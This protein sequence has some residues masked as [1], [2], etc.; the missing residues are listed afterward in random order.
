M[1]DKIAD[2]PIDTVPI[3]PEERSIIDGMFIHQHVPLLSNVVKAIV[4]Y[5]SLFAIVTLI[6]SLPDVLIST[7]I[8]SRF[9]VSFKAFVCCILFYIVT[10]ILGRL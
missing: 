3:S 2:L 9:L 6:Y 1:F 4:T 10:L 8:P 7:S 5:V